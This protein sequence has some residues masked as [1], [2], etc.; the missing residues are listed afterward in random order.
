MPISDIRRELKFFRFS[1][2]KAPWLMH[3]AWSVQKVLLLM[4]PTHRVNHENVNVM[5]DDGT[6][7]RMD[8]LTPK[9]SEGESLPTLLYFH[10]GGFGYEAAPHH[11][12]LTAMYAKK[13]HCRV[14]CPDYSLLPDFAYPKPR[15]DAYLAYEWL[16]NHYPDTPF[17]VGGDSAGGVLA[18]YIVADAKRTPAVCLLMYPV[19]DREMKTESMKKYLDTPMWNALNNKIM[20]ELYLKNGENKEASPMQMTLPQK[21]PPFY[22]ETAQFDCLHDDGVNFAKRL[23]SLGTSVEIVETRGTL[24]AFDIALWTR[25]VRACVKKRCEVLTKAFDK[26]RN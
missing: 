16:E 20:W 10:G 6:I 15:N 7:M 12:K 25:L 19:T 18:S 8:I 13:A 17:A 5:R 22:I 1:L 14:I 26:I 9:K 2:T 21:L 4:T 23:V 11:K 24:H 3:I